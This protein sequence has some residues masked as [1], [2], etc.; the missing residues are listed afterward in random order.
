MAMIT[1]LPLTHSWPIFEAAQRL[2]LG[3]VVPYDPD[4]ELPGQSTTLLTNPDIGIW[5]CDLR[6]NA[7]RWSSAVYEL[8]GL[9]QDEPVT[10][11]LTLSM[12]LPDG[13][14]AMEQ[15]RAYAI[16]HRRGFT[17]DARIRRPDGDIRW[18]RLSALPI[19]SGQRVMRL[20]GSKQ[21]VTAEY[22]GAGV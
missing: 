17:M 8:F 22:D 2:P 10:R 19:L 12:Y 11:P 16:K 20:C 3:G 18:M 5:Y 6:D 15:L 9:P 7:L 21:D 14:E 4:L 13:R 1:A